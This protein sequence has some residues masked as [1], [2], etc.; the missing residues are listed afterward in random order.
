MPAASMMLSFCEPVAEVRTPDRR[1]VEGKDEKDRYGE[2]FS[3][4]LLPKLRVPPS[5]VMFKS[6]KKG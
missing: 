4:Q 6:P 1:Q 3:E 2:G 5:N